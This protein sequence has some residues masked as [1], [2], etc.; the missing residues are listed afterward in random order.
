MILNKIK[1]MFLSLALACT[2]CVSHK[3]QY[4][5][6]HDGIRCPQPHQ[7]LASK[8]TQIKRSPSSEKAH[9]CDQLFVK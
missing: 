7:S 1:F 9:V 5:S 8:D 6:I 4:T 3:P 2:S